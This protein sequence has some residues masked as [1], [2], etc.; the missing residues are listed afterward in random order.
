MR[1]RWGL[2]GCAGILLAASAF[3]QPSHKDGRR[4]EQADFLPADPSP[5]ETRFANAIGETGALHT[6]LNYGPAPGNARG[7]ALDGG[8]AAINGLTVKGR[9]YGVSLDGTGDVLI[10]NFVFSDR[11]SK[12]IF[13]AGL[14]LGQKTP[15]RGETWLSHAW[16]DLK[17]KGPVPDYRLANNEAISIEA[18]SA[19]LNIRRAVLI[20]SEESGI[21]NKG[22]IRIDASFIASG[23]R[24]IRVWAGA[25]V[26]IANSIVLAHRGHAGLWFGGGK[27]EARLEYY[28][29]LFGTIGDRWEDLSQD[30]PAHLVQH[31][32]DDPVH[33]RLRRLDADPF[34]RTR[35]SFWVAAETPVPDGYLTG[36]RP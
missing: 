4:T 35:A 25:R 17:G 26:V 9:K 13:G 12:D 1:K 11:Q 30:P 6:G 7:L 5:F 16:I 31:D 2:L 28:N 8:D 18:G 33:V 23:H 34:T 15:T 3:A 22:T 29:C 10:R 21:D 36:H 24:S 19:P 32:E 14:I 20:G 27:G